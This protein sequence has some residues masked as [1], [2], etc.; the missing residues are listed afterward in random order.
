MIFLL[1]LA[2]V[3]AMI[4]GA[5]GF[6]LALGNRTRIDQLDSQIIHLSQVIAQQREADKPTP[7]P[8][9]TSPVQQAEQAKQAPPKDGASIQEPAK[10]PA[11]APVALVH[12]PQPDHNARP[13]PGFWARMLANFKQ[14]WVIWIAGLSL[15]LGSV[16]LV[17]YSIER[18]LFG[19]LARVVASLVFGATLIA[20]AEFLRRKERETIASSFSVP[21]A[22]AAGGLASLF[23]GVFAA[24]VLY[25]FT[26]ALVGFILMALVSFIG[27]A[28]G[29]I[30]GPVLAVIGLLGAFVTPMLVTGGTASELLFG[31]F[32]LVF[33]TSLAVERWQRWI[34]LSTLA[35]LGALFWGVL[36]SQK[37]QYS[38]YPALY[39]AILIGATVTIPAFGLPPKWDD[40][41]MLS[42]G[43]L[44]RISTSYPTV[45]ATLTAAI[46]AVLMVGLSL[47]GITLWQS[48]V[49]VGVGM[50]LAAVFG[51]SKA[52]NLDALTPILGFCSLGF[53]ITGSMLYQPPIPSTADA[54]TMVDGLRNQFPL[55]GLST[56]ANLAILISGAL[57]RLTRTVRPLFWVGLA[58]VAPVA[59]LPVLWLFWDRI[60]GASTSGWTLVGL[61]AAAVMTALAVQF[62]KRTD[63]T[64]VGASAF[65]CS[66]LLLL[67]MVAFVRFDGVYL[68]IS[69]AVLGAFAMWLVLRFKLELLPGFAIAMVVLTGF[70]LV[71]APGIQWG[72]FAPLD[73]IAIAFG[74]SFL[75]LTLG[76]I[77]SKRASQP[78]A[79]LFFETTA[80]STA[81]IAFCLLGA[82]WMGTT[83]SQTLVSVA[84][85]ALVWGILALSQFLRA[86]KSTELQ[87]LRTALGV[88]YTAIS[89]A[90]LVSALLPY[91]PLL[92]GN[93]PGPPVQNGLGF[94]YLLPALLILGAP[95]V[96]G[97]DTAWT[98]PSRLTGLGLLGLYLVLEL[99]H[100]WQGPD[101]RYSNGVG[102]E[103]L[104][105]YTAL[106]L[107]V[108]LATIGL[109]VLRPSASLRS[110]GL[111]FAALTALKVFLWD[112][113]G[114]EGLARAAAFIC[115]GLTLAGIGWL[116]QHFRIESP[117][118]DDSQKG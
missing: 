40:V 85:Y 104:Y 117:G 78:R 2:A 63:Q 37:F 72:L 69:F 45:L 26:N 57:W 38:A 10:S 7:E 15:A 31:Y 83:Q 23:A 22:L 114:L 106:M 70:R 47:A 11:E 43:S 53:I 111:A 109:S 81:A 39:F 77:L 51:L 16:F 108:S 98:K 116:H 102:Q 62:F 36:L 86:L 64:P 1:G 58:A 65:A 115:L 44:R 9:K 48:S 12:A 27:L 8:K 97:R 14:N 55:I 61:L 100:I 4:L 30:Y 20:A 17:Q 42:R 35:V 21:V 95:F 59:Y 110:A 96:L 79:L 29:L 80:M 76:A 105:S 74:G 92:R 68:T 18:G 33:V 103:E 71:A 60:S 107:L 94:S 5:V 50:L 67:L 66:A 118:P 82:R 93:F 84:L 113:S 24:H 56:L 19:P 88:L 32:L 112:M 87:N 99:R 90:F 34:W 3:T 46:V 91:S 89:A 75:V 13:G 41:R 28:G 101:L 52:E 25:G 73:Q 6:Y 54:T 49:L